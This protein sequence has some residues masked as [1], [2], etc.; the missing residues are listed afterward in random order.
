MS[1]PLKSTLISVRSERETRQLC[2]G[3]GLAVGWKDEAD[4]LSSAPFTAFLL[5]GVSRG[6]IPHDAA[7]QAP[8]L[9]SNLQKNL[10]FL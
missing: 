10:A 3:V 6:L 8:D 1:T 9:S 5:P 4:E 2:S 7:G